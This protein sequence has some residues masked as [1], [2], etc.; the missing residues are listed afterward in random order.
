MM[1][2]KTIIDSHNSQ[3][4]EEYRKKQKE[5]KLGDSNSPLKSDEKQAPFRVKPTADFNIIP[6]L[7]RTQPLNFSPNTS[8]LMRMTLPANQPE[9]KSSRAM[10]NIINRYC[11]LSKNRLFDAQ[12][13]PAHK[14]RKGGS[15]GVLPDDP[16]EPKDELR[17]TASV[18]TPDPSTTANTTPHRILNQNSHFKLNRSSSVSKK[19]SSSMAA[20]LNPE[21]FKA[22]RSSFKEMVESKT[23]AS[24]QTKEKRSKFI[25]SFKEMM[26][27]KSF[28]K[29]KTNEKTPESNLHLC[30]CNQE[31]KFK[32]LKHS[33]EPGCV[34]S[35]N[36]LRNKFMS[37]AAYLE[38][39]KSF[40]HK[41]EGRCVS[42][43]VREQ[44]EKDVVRT[45][46]SNKYLSNET[47]RG[48]LQKLL[49][50]VA[51]VY[52]HIGYVQGM[53][54]IAATLLYHC[55]EYCSLAIIRILFEQLELKDMFLP[56]KST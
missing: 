13:I 19:T 1:D 43:V 38:L 22:E 34:R 28:S 26:S 16:V 23:K 42:P 31:K 17:F 46:S 14:L 50:C 20:E 51:L 6:Q 40:D 10:D 11:V 41:Y 56:S 54:F 32:H 2:K 25:E 29:R 18:S 27:F 5:R 35:V 49:E 21:P 44:I 45:Y 3:T 8:P 39:K 47:V 48:R 37:N 7:I 15:F 52:P 30:G 24:H 4:M 12:P 53:N 33:F 55:D 36:W 9:G